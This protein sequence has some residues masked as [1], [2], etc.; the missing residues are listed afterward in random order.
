MN[1]GNIAA[2]ITERLIDYAKSDDVEP[3]HLAP[4]GQPLIIPSDSDYEPETFVLLLSDLQAG[5]KT[6]TFNFEVLRDRMRKL[7]ERTLRITALHR[8]SHPI[9]NLEIFLLGD[10]VHG[11]RV[12]KT[13]DLDELEDVVKVQMFDVVIPLLEDAIAEFAQNFESVKVRCVRGNHGK[14]SKENAVTSNWDDFI[15]YFLESR[16]RTTYNV[17]FTI[18]HRFFQIV[19]IHGWRFLLAHGDQINMYLNIPLYGLTNRSMRWQDTLGAFDFMCVGHFHNF[20]MMDWNHSQIIINGC[21][22]T[23]DE[24][25]AKVLGLSGSCSQVLMS[26]HPK[27]GVTFTSKIHLVG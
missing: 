9:P 12:G 16:F 21:F 11:E 6:E 3:L 5:H 27:R 17:E 25:V 13:V 24:W 19:D 23:D 4:P 20:A 7:V 10:L 1:K 15:Y 2:E 14:I 8:K 18:A 26:V 22:V